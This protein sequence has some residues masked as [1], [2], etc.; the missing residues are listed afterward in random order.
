MEQMDRVM[1]GLKQQHETNWAGLSIT[2][3]LF[4]DCDNVS[5]DL[6]PLEIYAHDNLSYVGFEKKMQELLIKISNFSD[7]K[8]FASNEICLIDERSA[9]K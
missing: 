2:A 1:L 8:F 7:I 4:P 5:E 9:F 3:A 6:Q